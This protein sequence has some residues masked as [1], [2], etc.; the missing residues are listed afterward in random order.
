M[1]KYFIDSFH[2]F[3][4]SSIYWVNRIDM[5]CETKFQQREREKNPKWM[6]KRRDKRMGIPGNKN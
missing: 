3:F 5:I 4:R 2:N 6:S 1:P